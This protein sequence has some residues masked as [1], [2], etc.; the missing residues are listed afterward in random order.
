MQRHQVIKNALDFGVVFVL[1]VISNDLL[2]AFVEV[3]PTRV[4]GHH[5]IQPRLNPLLQGQDCRFLVG[6]LGKL[7]PQALEVN[8]RQ[9]ILFGGLVHLAF[10]RYLQR[11]INHAAN[12]LHDC[13]DVHFW[14]GLLEQVVDGRNRVF[15]RLIGKH[16]WIREQAPEAVKHVLSQDLKRLLVFCGRA[17][18]VLGIQQFCPCLFAFLR[19][20]QGIKFVAHGFQVGLH[21]ADGCCVFS[22]CLIFVE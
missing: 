17:E 19:A 16:A 3:Y 20:H 5:A 8:A 12:L 4:L 11:G 14:F 22:K 18:R 9:V 7:N 6:R 21:L 13:G 10:G 1:V 15:L 2:I